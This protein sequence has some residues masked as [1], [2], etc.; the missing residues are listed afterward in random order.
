MENEI[1]RFEVGKTYTTRSACDYDCIYSYTV[2]SRTAKQ[3]TLEIRG[4]K[5]RRGVTVYENEE[6][7]RPEGNYSM[8]P[9]IHAGKF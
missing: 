3:I 5:V 7:C 6:Y 4:Q 2:L 8:C 1:K 9:V